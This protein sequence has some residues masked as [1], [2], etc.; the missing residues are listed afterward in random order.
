M[1][2]MVSLTKNEVEIIRNLLVYSEM[3]GQIIDDIY[4]KFEEL[5]KCKRG[6]I[7]HIN[8]NCEENNSTS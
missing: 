4:E 8:C 3:K 2:L 1:K 5:I 6:F 7:N